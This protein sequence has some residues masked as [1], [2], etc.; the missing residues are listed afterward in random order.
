M[1]T[2]ERAT[3]GV[4]VWLD[5]V[6]AVIVTVDG[7]ETKTEI[8]E[9]EVEK[10][11]RLAG[12]S[13]SATV[14]QAQDIA[15]ESTHEHRLQNQLAAYYTKVIRALRDPDELL[16]VGPGEAKHELKKALT[17]RKGA[18]VKIVGVESA[19]KM[20]NRQIAAMVRHRF[21]PA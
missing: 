18:R 20:T 14:Y 4:G 19:D 1:K 17:K 12:G 5:R 10:H 7:N 15:S 11:T 6:R 2:N 21:L 8:L 16:I 13:R 9:S 3:R